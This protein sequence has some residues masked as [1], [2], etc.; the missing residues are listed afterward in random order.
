LNIGLVAGSFG[1][2]HIVT[3]DKLK[4]DCQAAGVF[5]TLMSLEDDTFKIQKRF[6]AVS[7]DT[8]SQASVSTGVAVT[9]TGKPTI[10]ISTPGLG[11]I[12]ENTVNGCPIDFL[13][14]GTESV[15]GEPD[16]SGSNI[17]VR[18][19][20]QNTLNRIKIVH[21]DTLLTVDV[22]VQQSTTFGCHIMV[23]VILPDTYRAEETLLG[24]LGTP[25]G[26]M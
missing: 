13:V 10:Q 14:D 20:A 16:L 7:T 5:T 18:L 3:F 26:D 8:C 24:L 6:T 22:M 21:S 11:E 17:V 15:L 19:G 23:Q 2:P 1:D 4:F 9:D 25:N 12:S